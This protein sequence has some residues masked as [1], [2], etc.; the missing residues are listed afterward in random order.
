[1]TQEEAVKEEMRKLDHGH[2]TIERALNDA[3]AE[4]V[5]AHIDAMSDVGE[6]V[7]VGDDS[8]ETDGTRSSVPRRRKAKSQE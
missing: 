3:Y 8:P 4:G 1:M 7:G 5:K 6:G 2:T